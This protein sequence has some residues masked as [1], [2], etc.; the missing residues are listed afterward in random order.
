MYTVKLYSNRLEVK[1]KTIKCFVVNIFHRF[2][3]K[4]FNT[5]MQVSVHTIH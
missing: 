4:N 5:F 3:I 1:H 2:H